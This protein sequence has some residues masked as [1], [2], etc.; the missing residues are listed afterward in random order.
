[1]EWSGEERRQKEKDDR[2]ARLI[3]GLLLFL[4]AVLACLTTYGTFVKNPQD[5]RDEDQA[6]RLAQHSVCERSGNALRE[7]VRQEFVNL[8]RDSIIPVYSGVAR[9]IP[10]GERS[11]QILDH[12]VRHLRKRIKTIDRRIPDADCLELFPPLPGYEYPDE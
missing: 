10:D 1:M 8:K 4:V 7:D 11:K 9:T 5:R 2:R 12:A 6:I 3:A